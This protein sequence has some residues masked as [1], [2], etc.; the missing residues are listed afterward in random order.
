MVYGFFADDASGYHA[1]L[2][3][4]AALAR[5]ERPATVLA[6]PGHAPG[7]AAPAGR[8][9][10]ALVAHG[11]AAQLQGLLDRAA[12]ALAGGSRSS[13][14]CRSPRWTRPG[15]RPPRRGGRDGHEPAPR[16]PGPA[17]RRARGRP[18]RPAPAAPWLLPWS[19]A[20]SG[21]R[22]LEGR[23]RTLPVR[24][25]PPG[26][27]DLA[28]LAAGTPAASLLRSGTLLMAVLEA[29]AADPDAQRLD[30]AALGEALSPAGSPRTRPPPSA[31]GTSPR[32]S[33]ASAATAPERRGRPAARRRRGAAGRTPRSRPTPRRLPA[34]RGDAGA[35]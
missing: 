15:P 14:C 24:L 26:R 27:A 34:L 16:R 10:P 25:A 23:L 4:A 20:L 6:Y 9:P 19:A 33:R 30:A 2:L 12:A 17:G 22:R 11:A 21:C 7:P 1:A 29:A 32:A 3:A 5:V 13:S 18:G 8:R 31:S 28:A 35:R